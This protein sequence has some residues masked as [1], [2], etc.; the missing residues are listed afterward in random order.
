MI[1]VSEYKASRQ[2]SNAG[3]S[4][5]HS[6]DQLTSICA[7]ESAECKRQE[8]AESAE[9]P[10]FSPRVEFNKPLVLEQQHGP[11]FSPQQEVCAAKEIVNGHTQDFETVESRM[12]GF[13]VE[14][15]QHYGVP[16]LEGKSSAELWASYIAMPG[17]PVTPD[18]F[19]AFPGIWQ[20]VH[21]MYVIEYE[22]SRQNPNP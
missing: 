4:E 12:R 15:V 14:L 10:V 8:A 18:P 21:E 1:N 3:H 20:I 11:S 7:L 16:A 22:C 9:A 6:E 13:S 5:D 17:I 19:A 2:N